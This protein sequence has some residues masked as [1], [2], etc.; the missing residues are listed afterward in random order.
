[1]RQRSGSGEAVE[2]AIRGAADYLAIR[3]A[4]GLARRSGDQMRKPACA[5]LRR[6]EAMVIVGARLLSNELTGHRMMSL[7]APDLAA[8]V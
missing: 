2:N 4:W 8:R 1:M 3:L 5:T 6:V 7:H